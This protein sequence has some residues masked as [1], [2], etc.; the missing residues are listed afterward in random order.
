MKFKYTFLSLILLN[1]T[2]AYS[3]NN[4][5]NFNSLPHETMVNIFSYLN[6]EDL[7]NLKKTNKNLKNQIESHVSY[8]LNSKHVLLTG[9][10]AKITAW[11]HFYKNQETKSLAE[12]V[13]INYKINKIYNYDYYQ[14]NSNKL[15]SIIADVKKSFPNLKTLVLNE[16]T[17]NISD[18]MIFTV[19]NDTM[20]LTGAADN[21]RYLF[22]EYVSHDSK[23]KNVILNFKKDVYHTNT[24]SGYIV[25]SIAYK[26]PAIKTIAINDLDGAY[27][28]TSNFFNEDDIYKIYHTKNE[29][30]HIIRNGTVQVY[31]D[32]D[33][34]L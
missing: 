9:D 34:N 23:I 28:T 26:L 4:S 6:P 14:N 1:T 15:R 13:T 19:N 3:I 7:N 29:E 11:I 2:S 25:N 18:Q 32:K 10:Y 16:K 30:L 12:I 31:T 17:I 8:L 21:I 20:T 27:F 33:F 24:Y 5:S 22:E